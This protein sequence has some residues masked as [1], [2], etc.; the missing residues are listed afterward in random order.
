MLLDPKKIT[1]SPDGSFDII[2]EAILYFR[3]N[4]FFKN[5]AIEGDADKV[6]VYLTVFI[7]KILERGNVPDEKKSREIIKGLV[8]KCEYVKKSENFFNLLVTDD[9]NASSM[10][11]LQNYLRELRA[12][13]VDRMINILFDNPITKMDRKFWMQL[14]KKKFM[15]YD[16]PVASK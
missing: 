1:D 7:Q 16:M 5:F 12:E 8:E 11:N 13:T 10:T 14:G 3:A 4:V 6:L 9:H 2:D 15:N